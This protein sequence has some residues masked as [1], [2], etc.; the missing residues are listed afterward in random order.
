[1][2]RRVLIGNKLD[3]EQG[4]I[5]DNVSPRCLGT[6]WSVSVFSVHENKQMIDKRGI[7]IF[8]IIEYN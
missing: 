6:I 7:N 8:F 2:I 3:V 1:M 5:I 4:Y